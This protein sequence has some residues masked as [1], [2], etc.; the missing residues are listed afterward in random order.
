[1]LYLT[2]ASQDSSVGIATGYG[3]DDRGVR[4]LV[5]VG[6]MSSWPALGHTQP[7][8]QCVAYNLSSEIKRPERE[9]DHSRPANAEVKKM[10]I[11]STIPRYFFMPYRLIS[12]AQ[13]LLFLYVINKLSPYYFVYE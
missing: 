13:I 12:L 3:L 10:W 6:S 1:M 5:P 7:T 8:L 4:I 2:T 11:C 9:A